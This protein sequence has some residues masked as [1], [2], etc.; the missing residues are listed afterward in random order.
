[1]QQM[2]QWS[3]MIGYLEGIVLTQE[4]KSCVLLVHGVGYKVFPSP[5]AL[6]SLTQGKEAA[7]WIHTVVRQDAFELFG[8]VSNEEQ[9]FFEELISV[10]GV[11]PRGALGII[12][13]GSVKD[14]RT[15]IANN[16]VHYLTK[17]SGIG[18]RTAEKIVVELKDKLSSSLDMSLAGS[19]GNTELIEVLQSL[20]YSL[21]D[22][23][24]V[25]NQVTGS[26]TEEKIKSA[27]KLLAK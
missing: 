22:V 21:S 23:R 6:T 17:V 26:T 8:F 5:N 14:L 27:L 7:L 15:A 4:E 9:N 20:G 11:G 25:L 18:K 13:L 10:S 3:H 2:L 16:D 24:L 1:M 19:T 12:G